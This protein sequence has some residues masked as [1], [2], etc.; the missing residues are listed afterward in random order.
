MKKAKKDA[1]VT[2][3]EAPTL[4]SGTP[5]SPASCELLPAM[6]SHLTRL[7]ALPLALMP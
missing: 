3:A 5:Q 1:V 4:I 7:C 6:A 2:A